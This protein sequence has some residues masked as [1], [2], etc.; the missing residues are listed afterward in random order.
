MAD[1]VHVY[2]LPAIIDRVYYALVADS[3]PPQIL[4]SAQLPAA[5]W[6]RLDRQGFDSRQN[7]PEDA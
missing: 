1:G 7:T 2:N 6:P 4:L 5:V 3:Q